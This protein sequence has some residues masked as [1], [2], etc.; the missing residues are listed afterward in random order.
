M[1]YHP[2]EK[3]PELI[4]MLGTILSDTAVVYYKTHGFHWNVEGPEFYSLHKM[5]E[6][7]YETLWKSLDDT[8]ERIRA[9]GGKAPAGLAALLENATIAESDA[10][11]VAHVMIEILREN[12]IAL[13]K[14]AQEAAEF[15]D[16]QSDIVTSNMMADQ[17]T[18]LEKAAWM[19]QSARVSSN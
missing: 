11:P 8:A 16:T 15:S 9:L 2:G 10:T 6:E 18:F 17:A 19:L 7:F 12:Y 4:A 14:K 3:H 1:A 13:A 5:F